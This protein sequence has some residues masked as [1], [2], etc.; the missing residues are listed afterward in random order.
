[1]IYAV[2]DTNVIVSALLSRHIDA[3]TVIVRNY[4]LDGTVTPLYNE[5]I[6]QEY[7]DVLHRPKFEFPP[8]KVDDFLDALS[9]RGIL[10]GRTKSHEQFVDSADIV[11]YEVALS[12]EGSFLVTGNAKHFPSNP[13]VVS[14]TE[15]L[16]IIAERKTND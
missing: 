4:I 16:K 12:K 8:E 9:L 15:F 11:F 5:E 10:L 13:I 14:P 1:M 7:I 2:I 6:F 3:G